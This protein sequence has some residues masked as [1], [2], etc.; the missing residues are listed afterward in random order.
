[1]SKF[2]IPEIRNFSAIFIARIAYYY[3]VL[4]W[5]FW[6]IISVLLSIFSFFWHFLGYHYTQIMTYY[7]PLFPISRPIKKRAFKSIFGYI[8][9]FSHYYWVFYRFFGPK[10]IVIFIFFPCKTW[11]C[12]ILT[13]NCALLS[14]LF[15]LLFWSIIR[16][17]FSRKLAKML[18]ITLIMISSFISIFH[19]LNWFHFFWTNENQFEKWFYHFVNWFHLFYCF[20]T[21]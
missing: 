4:F 11:N 13:R 6:Y 10:I 20:F 14:E 17:F 3:R 16:V 12:V 8:S 2:Y 21:F 18:K 15:F 9:V 5:L 1:M 7:R 19:F